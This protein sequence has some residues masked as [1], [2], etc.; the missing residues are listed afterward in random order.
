MHFFIDPTKLTTQTS[1]NKKF[2]P[3]SVDPQDTF[4]ISTEFTLTEEARAFACQKGTMVIQQSD[5][6]PNLVN[7]ILKPANA[8]S[9]DGISVKYYVYRGLTLDSFFTNS[10]S[11]LAIKSKDSSTAT[12][13]IKDFWENRAKEALKRGKPLPTPTPFN[14]G[15]GK[16]ELPLE[17]PNSLNEDIRMNR[18]FNL[19]TPLRSVFVQEG[20][21]IGNFTDSAEI[22]FEIHLNSELRK[23]S[24]TLKTSRASA[25]QI[26][27]GSNSTNAFKILQESINSYIDPA[28]FFGLHRNVG[29]SMTSYVAGKWITKLKKAGELYTSVI[30]KFE[31]CGRVYLDIR[32]ERGM[33]YNYCDNY[34]LNVNNNLINIKF[35]SNTVLYGVEG[36]PIHYFDSLQFDGDAQ[37][38]KKLTFKLI[39]GNNNKPIVFVDNVGAL[40]KSAAKQNNF[41]KEIGGSDG[42]TKDIILYPPHAG[43]SAKSDLAF[44]IKIYYFLD[45]PVFP[46]EEGETNTHF[47]NSRYFDSAFCSVDIEDLGSSDSLTQH[48]ENMSVTYIK[49]PLHK[50]TDTNADKYC[51]GTGNFS[52]AARTGA[53]W[54]DNRILFYAKKH[55]VG[56]KYSVDSGK[57][58]LPTVTRK[59]KKET[60][61]NK[62]F[63]KTLS[64]NIDIVCKK[65]NTTDGEIKII[66]LNN[67]SFPKKDKDPV[68]GKTI[69]ALDYKSKE[70][71]IL[72]GLTISELN[73]VKAATGI[74]TNHPRF[75]YL[76]RNFEN[77]FLID[78]NKE[79]YFKYTVKVQGLDNE[80]NLTI[81]NPS[82]PISVYSRDN[83]FFTSQQFAETEHYS[84]GRSFPGENM[85]EYRIIKNGS[86]IINDNIDL[87]LVKKEKVL[88][89]SSLTKV[90]REYQNITPHS[91]DQPNY[92]LAEEK[93]FIDDDNEIKKINY[94]YY[95]SDISADSITETTPKYSICNLSIISSFRRDLVTG[96]K[97]PSDLK[98]IDRAELLNAGC[99]E[100]FDYEQASIEG[101][102]AHNS[103]EKGLF[104]VTVGIYKNVTTYKIYKK[105]P[106]KTFM[107]YVNNDDI[108]NSEKINNRF[109]WDETARCFARPD[110]FAAY[111]GMLIQ[112][113]FTVVCEGFA[114]PD[115][116]CFP[117]NLH[118]NGDA[119]DTDYRQDNPLGIIGTQEQ[120]K[121]IITALHKF[122]TGH[123]R[124]GPKK[125][126]LRKSINPIMY[127]KKGIYWLEGYKLHDNHLHTEEIVI[128]K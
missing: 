36:W 17:N 31:N 87:S 25:M 104:I 84:F 119:F 114:Y 106:I 35:G 11:D 105:S 6:N 63:V 67:Y 26:V 94:V 66:G 41:Y 103:Y 12:D 43:N 33:S 37:N 4:N 69:N 20:T 8:T 54:D 95:D 77:A 118:V 71:L 111:L 102:S 61:D 128:K 18:V 79:R 72:L 42:W 76:V 70:D 120:D 123:F 91:H 49:E 98:T 89:S 52:Y 100:I 108:N 78:S 82:T 90:T 38:R 112:V 51:E 16:N 116:T 30:S 62:K 9:I 14:L 109:I 107:V 40:N 113:G 75:I 32:N 22:S 121:V 27:R 39:K 19:K 44:Y 56:G 68:T 65:Y 97:V 1:S 15:Y 29:V 92:S 3:H 13:F 86:I 73:S 80:G 110:L 101:V 115:G 127:S 7:A 55:V 96:G 88:G 50:V 57:K 58:Y 125:D 53:Y 45:E 64:K 74:S 99:T 60:L 126:S 10:G 81:V 21:W 47:E 83:Q 122:G 24:L 117:S 2:G 59:L 23:K 93:A 46:P 5:D 85:I 48:V 28:A 34:T 124:I